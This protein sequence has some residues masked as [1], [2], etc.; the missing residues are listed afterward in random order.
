[1]KI[2]KERWVQAQH[3][4]FQEFHDAGSDAY[5]YAVEKTFECLNADLSKDFKGKVIVEVG[6]GYH[7]ALLWA[8]GLKKAIAVDPLFNTWPD[9]YK[10]RCVDYG[11]EIIT[12]PYE[13]CEVGE[14][15]ETW[16]FNVLQHVIDPEVQ[17]KRAMETSKVVR[18]FEPIGWGNGMP[19]TINDAHPHI[20][21]KE[22][23]T[24]VM[25]DFGFIY[26]ACQIERFHQAECYYGT[27]IK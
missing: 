6:T 8:K 2:T 26:N 20:I 9:Q 5:Q 11:M 7:P 24:N 14:V 10:Q 15:D 16:L 1:M 19:L 18:I 4:E 27:W 22:T 3:A 21:S 23:I 25:G 13:E 17:L 12:D